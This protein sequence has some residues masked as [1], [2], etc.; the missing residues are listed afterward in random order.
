M[1]LILHKYGLVL[2]DDANKEQPL[3]GCVCYLNEL[4]GLPI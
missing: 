2:P 3:W 4:S 1:W